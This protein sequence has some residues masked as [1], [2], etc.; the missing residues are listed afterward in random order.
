[1]Q[2]I[3]LSILLLSPCLFIH[4]DNPIIF[5]ESDLI[6]IWEAVDSNNQGTSEIEAILISE[7][8]S[9]LYMEDIAIVKNSKELEYGVSTCGCFIDLSLVAERVYWFKYTCL[10]GEFKQ[11]VKMQ[12]NKLIIG[13]SIY[14]KYHQ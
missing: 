5:N 6:G 9:G 13:N 1:M 11:P 14:Q 10:D 2:K 3:L 4:C 12:N 7:F 8:E